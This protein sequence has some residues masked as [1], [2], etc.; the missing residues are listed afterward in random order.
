MKVTYIVSVNRQLPVDQ[1]KDSIDL[2]IKLREED[3]NLKNYLVGLELS[4]DPRSGH[5]NDF[6]DEF[7]RARQSGIKISLHCSEIKE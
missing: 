4:G 6:K 7:E 3:E 5:F 2:L 1:A